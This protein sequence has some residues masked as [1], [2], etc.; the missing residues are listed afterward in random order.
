M[1]QVDISPRYSCIFIRRFCPRECSYCT[2]R[3]VRG[4]GRLLTPKE[5]AE[6]LHI[7]ESHGV[8]FHLIL[9]NELFSYPGCVDL[10]TEL[11]AFWERYAIYT[12]FP[13]KWTERWL[14]PCIDAGLYN[15]SCGVDVPPGVLTGDKDVD[16][17]A[18]RGLFY[19]NYCKKAGVPDVHATATIHRHNYD[20]LEP[21]FDYCT[22]HGIWMAVSMVEY[23]LDGKHDFYGGYETM[24][25]WLIPAAERG[26]FRDTMYY[27]AEQVRSG[28]WM[29]QVPP[30]Y[31][32]EIGRRE[33]DQD[34]WHCS[35]PTII[36]VEEDGTLRGCG[37]RGP[38]KE[39]VSVFELGELGTLTMQ[40]YIRRQ[41]ACTS[42]CPGCGGGGGAWSFWWQSEQW[43]EGDITLGD[44]VFQTHFP[45]YAF[46]K[47]TEQERKKQDK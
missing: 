19:L 9:G 35:L 28:R 6:A 4:A 3:N 23:S 29:M 37:Y 16:E 41:R 15:I 13:H 12:T 40:E 14:Q 30:S 18:D 34:P 43:F 27:L 46:E 36:S 24:K 39:P 33:Y 31:F 21:L 5:W 8:Q 20:K 45:G 25:D 42:E 17:K 10:V 38:L 47:I 44:K 11:K 7:L 22:K 26:R 2:A 32:E 1:E